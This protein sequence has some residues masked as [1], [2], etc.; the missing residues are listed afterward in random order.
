[1]D[2]CGGSEMKPEGLLYFTAAGKCDN[3]SLVFHG[4]SNP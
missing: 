2:W 1:M 4:I 3:I